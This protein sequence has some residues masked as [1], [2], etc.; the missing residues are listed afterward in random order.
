VAGLA[1]FYWGSPDQLSPEQIRTSRHHLLV[2]RHL[3]WSSCHQVAC[4]LKFF[5]P[6]TLGWD[7]LSLHLPPRTRRSQLP[8][9]LSAEELQR[10]FSR[11]KNPQHRALLMT[12]DAAGLRVSE[13]VHLQVTDIEGE[14]GLMRVNQG[15]G[16]KDRYTLLSARLLAALR[17]YWT[18][19][20]GKPWR[21]PG[22]DRNQPMPI[23]SAPRIYYRAKHAANLQQ[24][25]GIHT[26]RH[27]FAPH[28]LEAGVDPRTIPLWLGPRALDPTTRYLRVARPHR[29]NI[30]RPFDL[31]RV[32]TLPPLGEDGGH[33][34]ARKALPPIRR[35]GTG[36]RSTVGSRRP[37]APLWP[38]I[39]RHT[40][41]ATTPPEGAA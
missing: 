20:R 5:Y 9:V 14:R 34:P 28:L 37:L 17:A 41:R 13:V 11:A 8:H 38:D 23:L 1:K 35:Q 26:L 25:K 16:R 6:K 18:L 10:L 2:A 29:A 27:S 3:A 39:R 32:D 24:G 30:Q 12:P 15:K 33:G 19:E 36:R 31:V 7:T 4:G 40:P 22:Q 21:C